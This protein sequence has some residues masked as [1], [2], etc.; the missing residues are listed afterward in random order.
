MAWLALALGFLLQAA[1]PA[2]P[3]QAT[4]HVRLRQETGPATVSFA[5]GGEA[6][7]RAVAGVGHRSKAVKRRLTQ[8]RARVVADPPASNAN[9]C[10]AIIQRPIGERAPLTIIASDAPDP[11]TRYSRIIFPVPPPR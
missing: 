2:A 10:P 3:A 1:A 8:R 7:A 9:P 5:G 6:L 4:G 11:L